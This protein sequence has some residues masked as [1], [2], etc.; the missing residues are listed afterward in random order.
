MKHLVP[1]L[2]LAA[3][4]PALSDEGDLDEKLKDLEWLLGGWE[5]QG[6]FME[7]EFRERSDY[8]TQ[9]GGAVIVEEAYAKDKDGKVIHEDMMFIWK[10][11]DATRCNF[12]EAGP[13]RCTEFTLSVKPDAIDFVPVA[14]GGPTMTFRATSEGEFDF[15]YAAKGPDG[16]DLKASG[17]S[18]RAKAPGER[19]EV[20]PAATL[21]PLGNGAGDFTGEALLDGKKKMPET[22][23]GRAA[24]GGEFLSVV[25]TLG[26]KQPA[27]IRILFWPDAEGDGWVAHAYLPDEER[28]VAF[29]GPAKDGVF[30]GTETGGKGRT[31]EWSWSAE[32]YS[33]RVVEDPED[34]EVALE[35]SGKRK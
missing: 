3:T 8:R 23:S 32:G 28:L 25:C 15:A 16:R 6:K 27:T 11:K 18:R 31:M 34:N 14:A 33:W 19:G 9:F 22:V 30:K 24:I 5:G 13:A 1:A 4:L 20:E 12:Y 29:R 35:G 21:A 10:D 26:D 17:T 2:V 7:A